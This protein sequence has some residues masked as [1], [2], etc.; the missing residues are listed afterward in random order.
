MHF[1]RECIPQNSC[2]QLFILNRASMIFEWLQKQSLNIKRE[3]DLTVLKYALP[4]FV[5]TTGI[6]SLILHYTNKS[7]EKRKHE[8]GSNYVEN[9]YQLRYG[10]NIHKI[11]CLPVIYYL[12]SKFESHNDRNYLYLSLH[13]TYGILWC[14]KD[15]LFG[16]KT[17][18]KSEHN[19]LYTIYSFV[20]LEIFYGLIPPIVSCLNLGKRKQISPKLMFLSVFV[21]GMGVFFH[22]GSDCQKYYQLKY[23]KKKELITNGFFK[24]C[25][26]PNYVGEILIYSSFVL[27]SGHWISC[28]SISTIIL[29]YVIDGYLKK[30][31]S[32]SRYQNWKQ[33]KLNTFAFIPNIFAI[34]Q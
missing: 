22:F 18:Q 15:Y 26:H 25:R 27:V 20:G 33:Y 4:C 2:L 3:S 23:N 34:N 7:I 17:Y 30:E 29:P 19:L 9:K 16:D 28:L 24:L 10:I 11:L 5:A 32:L 13:G 14:L 12:M 1:E 31:K 8:M 6:V 21:W